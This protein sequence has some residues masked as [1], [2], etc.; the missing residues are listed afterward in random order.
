MESHCNVGKLLELV[1]GPQPVRVSATSEDDV[2]AVSSNA[3][4]LATPDPATQIATQ[5]V[6]APEPEK[7][8]AVDAPDAKKKT[9]KKN[10]P[11]DSRRQG[12]L[13]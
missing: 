7:I 9:V 4:S 6:P 10:K 1:T 3:E 8:S 5:S 13:F 2:E 11:V 12:N